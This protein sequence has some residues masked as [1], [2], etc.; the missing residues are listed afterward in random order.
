MAISPI[1]TSLSFSQPSLHPILTIAYALPPPTDS[2]TPAASFALTFPDA[3]FIDPDELGGKWPIAAE[4]D[5][6]GSD[7]WTWALEPSSV[8]IERPYLGNSTHHTLH[9]RLNP[10]AN[11]K[12]Q[13]VLEVPLHARYLTPSDQGERTLV[14]PGEDGSE[15]AAGWV[16]AESLSDNEKALELPLVHPTP[17]SLTLPT[18]KHA[19]QELVELV[20]PVVIWLG[21]AWIMWKLWGL[22][23]RRTK[24]KTL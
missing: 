11:I 22:T 21:W 9:I 5:E 8:D 17:I 4:E 2:C 23:K 6:S 14:F 13:E 20:T 1:D 19:H 16:C 7:V 15:L 3:L 12:E 18:G 24:V 10:S